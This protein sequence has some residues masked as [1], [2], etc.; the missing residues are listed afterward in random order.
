MQ[1]AKRRKKG[2]KD[3]PVISAD[4]PLTTVIEM[5]LGSDM[6]AYVED[7]GGNLVGLVSKEDVHKA[8]VGR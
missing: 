2:H 5:Q 4:T 1:A 6:P 7:E 8:L 3:A